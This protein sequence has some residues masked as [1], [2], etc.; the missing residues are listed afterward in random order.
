[1]IH[2]MNSHS[3]W[4]SIFVVQS[5]NGRKLNTH[6]KWQQNNQL[7]SSHKISLVS[8]YYCLCNIKK[9]ERWMQTERRQKK[10]APVGWVEGLG[11]DSVFSSVPKVIILCDV[12]DLSQ[13]RPQSCRQEHLSSHCLITLQIYLNKWH[14]SLKR[15]DIKVYWISHRCRYILNI[16]QRQ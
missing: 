6:I 10:P 11:T 9:T 4:L 15:N 5:K 14:T 12:S 2:K 16:F 3:A 1:M 13:K 8:K 7:F